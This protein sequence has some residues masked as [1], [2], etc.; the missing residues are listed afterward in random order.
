MYKFVFLNASFE[1]SMNLNQRT[2]FIYM[3]TR[4][5]SH[6]KAIDF[7]LALFF[8]LGMVCLANK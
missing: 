6:W 1:C 2:S 3:Q 5:V 4:R 7:G 8:Y